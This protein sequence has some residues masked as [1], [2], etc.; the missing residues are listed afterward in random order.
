VLVGHVLLDDLE[1]SA[2]DGRD[3]VAVGPQ[4]R[5]PRAKRGELLSHESGGATLDGLHEPVDAE[6]RINADEEVDVVGHGLELDEL[7]SCLLADLGNDL[8]QT[9][10]DAAAFVV[11]DDRPS[12]LRGLL[13]F[14]GVD[15]VASALV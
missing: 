7:G 8:L 14:P 4:C 11:D 12:V 6:L 13:L 15:L 1:R 10:V 3:E 5:E 2:A 9:G